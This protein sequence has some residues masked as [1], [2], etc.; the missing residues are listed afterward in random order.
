MLTRSIYLIMRQK[1]IL[2]IDEKIWVFVNTSLKKIVLDR[3][4]AVILLNTPSTGFN[5]SCFFYLTPDNFGWCWCCDTELFFTPKIEKRE[6]KLDLRWKC[7]V[8]R[9]CI[10]T[11][12]KVN[13]STGQICDSWWPISSVVVLMGSTAVQIPAWDNDLFCKD[14]HHPFKFRVLPWTQNRDYKVNK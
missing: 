5:L 6:N 9:K 4:D 14:L 1:V 13:H 3:D 10:N 2:V 12:R 7:L 8:E 11:W